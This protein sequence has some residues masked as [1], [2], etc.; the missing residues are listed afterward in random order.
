MHTQPMQVPACG[1]RI[2]GQ[3]SEGNVSDN[4]EYMQVLRFPSRVGEVG[5][6][7]D[8]VGNFGYSD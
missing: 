4:E 8:I 3:A 6:T 5:G 1:L 2:Q 7:S